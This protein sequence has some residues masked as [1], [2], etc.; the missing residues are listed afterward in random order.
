MD[1][2]LKLNSFPINRNYAD[3]DSLCF[4]VDAYVF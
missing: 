1:F 2:S 3:V 4:D